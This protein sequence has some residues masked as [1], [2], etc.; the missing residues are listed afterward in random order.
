M[1]KV[2]SVMFRPLR[3]YNLESRAHKVISK[4]KPIPAPKHHSDLKYTEFLKEYPDVDQSK[5]EALNKFLQDVYVTSRDPTPHAPLD[6]SSAKRP[7]P[8]H[9]GIVDDAEFGFREPDSVPYGRATLKS[10]LKF[11]SAHQTNPKENSIKKIA[12]EYKL[13]EDTLV[14]I[15]KYYRVFEVYIPSNKASKVSFAGPLVPRKQ[16]VAHE[17]KKLTDGKD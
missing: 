5:N 12:E 14:N 6:S 10:A 8:L 16:I 13:H 17:Q 9:R 3:D 4:E 11:I 2:L 7:L 15:L 1:G